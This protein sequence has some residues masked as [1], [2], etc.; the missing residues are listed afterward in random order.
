M[1]IPRREL[2]TLTPAQA[3]QLLSA[4]EDFR[5]N[6]EGRTVV[7]TRLKILPGLKATVSF[8]YSVHNLAKAKEELKKKKEEK[9]KQKLE[10]RM[11]RK[12]GA[13]K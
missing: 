7:E 10:K 9:K 13:V 4:E 1:K 3:L 2:D 6:L 8:T 12:Q 5:Q 11:K